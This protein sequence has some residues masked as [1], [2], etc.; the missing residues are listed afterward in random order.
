M[1]PYI[2]IYPS[3]Q[4]LAEALTQDFRVWVNESSWFTVALSGGSTPRLWFEIL[5]SASNISWEKV[6]FFWGDERCVPPDHAE[7]NFRMT[8]ETLLDHIPIS[9]AHIHRIQGEAEPE[10]EAK[11]YASEITQHLPSETDWPVFDLMLLGLGTDGHT[12]SIFP[13]QMELLDSDEVCA[14][15]QHPDSGQQRISL[16]GN[17]INQARKVAFLVTGEKKADILST[18]LLKKENW[19]S[20]PASHITAR[21]QLLFYLDETAARKYVKA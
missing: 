1:E 16:T 15:A 11:R 18:I 5:A 21:E 17:V 12:A 6:H 10:K 2:Q 13:H 3:P 14:V 7:S 4:A 9:P 19:Q 8:R 20:Y